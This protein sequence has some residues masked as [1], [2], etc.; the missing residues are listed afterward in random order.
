MQW[1]AYTVLI[2]STLLT[3]AIVYWYFTYKMKHQKTEGFT[4]NEKIE[5]PQANISQIMETI[6]RLSSSFMD[7][8]MWSERV[9]MSQMTPTE[10]AR[11][12]LNSKDSEDK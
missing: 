1:I 3:I 5:I 6:Q 12:Y 7:M 9:T 11:K 8:N 2:V 10:L 4:E